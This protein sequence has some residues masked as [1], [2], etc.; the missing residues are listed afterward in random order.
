MREG[1]SHRAKNK[2][3]K[4][5]INPD[6]A[7]IEKQIWKVW[8]SRKFSPLRLSESERRETLSCT[9]FS[10]DLGLGAASS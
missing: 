5:I 9:K 4:E 1:D 6:N 2:V 10:V 3:K 8:N 7:A